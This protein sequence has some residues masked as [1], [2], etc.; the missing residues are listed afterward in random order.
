MSDFQRVIDSEAVSGDLS[1]DGILVLTMSNPPLNAL[2]GPIR[3]GLVDAVDM[4]NADPRVVGILIRGAGRAFCAGADIR[5]FGQAASIRTGEVCNR[6]EASGKVVVAAIHGFALGGGLEVALGSHYRIAAEGTRV[7]L[8]E[9]LLGTIPGGGGTQRLPRLV[10]AAR[11]LDI[12]LSARQVTAIEAL[13][14]GIVDRVCGPD[15]LIEGLAFIRELL[16]EGAGPRRTSE[17]QGLA[18]SDAMRAVSEARRR[19]TTTHYMQFAAEKLVDAV[20]MAVTE[21]FALGMHNEQALFDA[22]LAN[23]Q[24]GAQVHAF[25]S[26]RRT[27]KAPTF[28]GLKAPSCRHIGIVGQ[29]NSSIG[30]VKDALQAPGARVSFIEFDGSTDSSQDI[31]AKLHRALSDAGRADDIGRLVVSRYLDTLTS[32]DFVIDTV[33]WGEEALRRFA[34]TC[35][36]TAFIATNSMI[37]DITHLPERFVGFHFVASGQDDSVIEVVGSGEQNPLAVLAAFNM[38]KKM[39][40]TPVLAAPVPGLIA[41]RSLMSMLNVAQHLVEHGVSPYRVDTAM[42]KFGFA[43]GPFWLMDTLGLDIVDQ[44]ARVIPTRTI[45]LST[46][47]ARQCLLKNGFRGV[48]TKR[49]FYLYAARNKPIEDGE[50]VR[51]L[52]KEAAGPHPNPRQYSDDDIVRRCVAALI[53]EGAALVEESVAQRPSDIDVLHIKAYGF[54]RFRGGPMRYADD[55]GIKTVIEDLNEFKLEQRGA[56]APSELLLQLEQDG[57]TFEGFNSDS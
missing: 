31:E 1:K 6:I 46:G 34:D 7:G 47:N 48:G 10:G 21:P 53:N 24:R 3:Q 32:A 56:W 25:F 29:S 57:Q 17:A 13:E 40:R 54:P 20:E 39:N 55:Y 30:L 15:V 28:D 33:G 5:G 41:V 23:E 45:E 19:I 11:A 26:E 16:G 50:I 42:R 49:G 38:A 51:M 36:P 43:M 12:M 14:S 18:R 2:N 8:P 44:F 52:E 4:A 22:C 37:A 35:N 27:T 9:I